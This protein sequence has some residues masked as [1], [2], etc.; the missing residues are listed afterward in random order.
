MTGG[1]KGSRCDLTAGDRHL[2][3]ALPQPELQRVEANEPRVRVQ[4]QM[5]MAAVFG[6]LPRELEGLDQDQA[7][8]Y[9]G[10]ELVDRHGIRCQPDDVHKR[11]GV[12]RDGGR[13][14]E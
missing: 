13:R 2:L 14:I 8:W 6:A 10:F 7:R 9:S 11:T 3:E 4:Q 12:E 5:L 1:A